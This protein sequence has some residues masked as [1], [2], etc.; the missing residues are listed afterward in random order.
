[1]AKL[2]V[3][4]NMSTDANLEVSLWER[5]TDTMSS[6]SEGIVG[7]LGRLFGSSN[8]RL[9]RSIGYIRPKGSETHSVAPGSILDRVNALEPLMLELHDDEFEKLTEYF[10]GRL[11]VEHKPFVKKTATAFPPA[12]NA[13]EASPPSSNGEAATPSESFTTLMAL[14]DQSLPA[15]PTLDDLLPY[16][17]A[18]CREVSRRHKNMRHFDVQ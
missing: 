17:F 14:M 10:R 12:P 8:D 18:A 16:A 11:G 4:E 6:V 7:F 2:Y 9:V 15:E 1:M 13:V 5:F 3:R